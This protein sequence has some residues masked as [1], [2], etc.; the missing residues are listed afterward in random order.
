MDACV[1][2]CGKAFHLEIASRDFESEYK[3]LL[4]KSHP[5]VQQK[6]KDLLKRWA[7]GEF[8]SDPQLNLIPSFFSKLKSEGI[9]F[10][11]PPEMVIQL[12]YS[13]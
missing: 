12:N 3:K 8:K 10:S 4:H 2:N 7:E 6:L 1:N 5:I 13:K 9:D 11:T